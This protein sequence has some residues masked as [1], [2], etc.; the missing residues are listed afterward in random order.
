MWSFGLI[1]IVGVLGLIALALALWS[2]L[3]PKN[4]SV[5]HLTQPFV[6]MPTVARKDMSQSLSKETWWQKLTTSRQRVSQDLCFLYDVIQLINNTP[7]LDSVLEQVLKELTRHLAADMGRIFLLDDEGML[8]LSASAG[9]SLPQNPLPNWEFTLPHLVLSAD[10]PIVVPDLRRWPQLQSFFSATELVSTLWLP[11]KTGARAV[12]IL[13]LGS[14]RPNA[15]DRDTAATVSM[16]ASH[17]ATAAENSRLRRQV[18]QE[19]ALSQTLQRYVSPRLVTTFQQDPASRRQESIDANGR[20][21]V[22][23]A[24]VRS[25][26]SLM[27]KNDPNAVMQVLNKYFLRMSQ[28]I[29]ANGGTVDEFAGDQIV[30]SFDRSSP[31]VND[32]RRAVR[33]GVEMLTAL[34]TLQKQWRDRGQPTFDIGIGIST[35]VVTRGSI[36]SQERKALVALGS[37]LNIAS[38]AEEMNKK[39]STHL[40]ITQSTFEQVP[41]LIEYDALGAHELQ[42]VSKPVPLYSVRGMK[43]SHRSETKVSSYEPRV[44]AQI[45]QRRQAFAE[46]NGPGAG[47]D[48]LS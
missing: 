12:G 9:S 7:S 17:L 13:G 45:T 15:F 22:L 38:R 2:R 42:G 5:A 29:R 33:A 1:V 30:A 24:D 14:R 32:A 3:R 37:I 23:F 31:R 34:R 16:V 39:F 10:K 4:Q 41:N 19:R 35:G 43:N 47:T 46:R 18:K 6:Y 36:G 21:S 27:E 25:F 20:I 11:L 40:I 28:I 48:L 44:I 8:Q 26:T